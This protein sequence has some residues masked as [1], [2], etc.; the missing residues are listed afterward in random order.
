MIYTAGF[1]FRDGYLVKFPQ[2]FQWNRQI[3]LSPVSL[4]LAT[5]R[6]IVF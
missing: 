1:R 5:F 4:I 2:N 3:N 6:S